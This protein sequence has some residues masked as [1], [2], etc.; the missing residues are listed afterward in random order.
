MMAHGIV[1]VSVLTALMP[2]LSAAAADGRNQDLIAHLNNGLRLVSVV[3]VPI[4]AAYIVLDRP[5][6]VTLFQWGNYDHADALR[7]APVIAV[8]G[9]G[10]VPYAIMQLQQF[11]FYALRDTRTPALLNVPVVALRVGLDLLFWWLLPATAVAAAMMGASGLSFVFGALVSIYLLRRRLGLLRLRRVASALVRL[12]GAAAIAA[13]PTYILVDVLSR[14]FGDGK[15]ASLVHLVA[16]GILL[17]GL[18]YWMALLLRVAEVR[19]LTRM[20][21]GRLGRS[22]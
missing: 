6:A 1:A 21:K 22:G 18:Y 5:I 11:A 2:R 13:V 14:Q 4:T 19:D 8:A 15:M 16:G 3:L 7:T 20:V 10:L 9:L 17:L 12:V